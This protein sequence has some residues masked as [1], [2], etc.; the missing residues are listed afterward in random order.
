MFMKK[1]IFTI[2][3]LAF[4]LSSFYGCQTLFF[5][6]SK[7]VL[8]HPETCA[9]GPENIFIKTSD[10]LTIHSWLFRAKHQPAKGTVIFAH[11]NSNNVSTESLGVLWLLY[12]G[13]N[14]FAFDYRGF[15]ISRGKPSIKGVLQD[16]VDAIDAFMEIKNL[17]KENLILYGQSLGGAVAVYTAANSKYADKFKALVL[18]STFTSWR[19][20]AREAADRIFVTWMFQYPI[21]WSFPKDMASIDMIKESKI[22][23]TLVVHSLDD[24]V[25]GFPNGVR[26]YEAANDPKEFIA[27]E[28][29]PHAQIFSTLKNRKLLIEYLDSIPKK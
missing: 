22:K 3:L 8:Y 11:G 16:G 17:E 29:A 23:N 10:N 15:G 14:I 12:E 21:S 28:K 25:V 19:D 6:P 2:I 27:I 24:K 1:R 18:E 7:A 5:Y 26:L 20:M 4:S 13:Y 9:A